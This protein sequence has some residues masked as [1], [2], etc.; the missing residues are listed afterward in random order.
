VIPFSF[1]QFARLLT[2]PQSKWEKEIN[3]IFDRAEAKKKK[4]VANWYAPARGVIQRL[5]GGSLTTAEALAQCNEWKENA[6]ELREQAAK[7]PDQGS[8]EQKKERKKERERLRRRASVLVDNA[9]MVIRFTEHFSLDG[10]VKLKGMLF[11]Y[12]VHAVE[13]QVRPNLCFTRNGRLQLVQLA[14]TRKSKGARYR[15]ILR[16]LLFHSIYGKENVTPRDVYVLNVLTSE[17][18]EGKLIEVALRE[19]MNNLARA[20]ET[21]HQSRAAS[22]AKK[23]R[24]SPRATH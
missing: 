17:R 6:T 24:P 21:V 19:E 14:F 7:I 10:V 13:L 23:D 9:D 11:T 4:R 20:I 22:R 5:V 3:R 18:I 12:R 15:S 16:K 8:K 1:G 2:E